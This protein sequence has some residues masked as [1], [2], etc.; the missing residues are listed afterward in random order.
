L[1]TL[2]KFPNGGD[3]LI[4]WACEKKGKAF[5]IL[6][7]DLKNHLNVHG[8]GRDLKMRILTNVS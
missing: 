3:I 2:Q 5:H 1:D 8:D 6:T 7:F 4:L